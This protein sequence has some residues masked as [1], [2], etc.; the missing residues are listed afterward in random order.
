[1]EA[2]WAKSRSL[3]SAVHPAAFAPVGMPRTPG[4]PRGSVAALL[5][6]VFCAFSRLSAAELS[7][8]N[9]A[10]QH[11][12]LQ[13][14]LGQLVPVPTNAVPA[15]LLPP[16]GIGVQNQIPQPARGVSLPAAVLRR[17]QETQ[18]RQTN[19]EFFPAAQLKLM[20]YLG[21]QDEMGNTAFRPDPLIDITPWDALAQ[22][23]KYWVSQYGVRYALEQTVTFVSMTDGMRGDHNLGF[24]T[25]DFPAK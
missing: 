18:A 6:C 11:L 8:T 19:F 2:A 3:W 21:A 24:Y 14:S 7:T 13:G 9:S 12:L 23:G 1:M 15:N 17:L 25:L 10:P 5:L 20:P 4:A 16:P 22:S